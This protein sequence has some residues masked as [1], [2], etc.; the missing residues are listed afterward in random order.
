MG[1]NYADHRNLYRREL[2]GRRTDQHGQRHA[3]FL[4]T[5]TIFYKMPLSFLEI[6][7]KRRSVLAPNR[8]STLQPEVQTLRMLSF[9]GN[10]LSAIKSNNKEWS[11]GMC[12]A[13]IHLIMMGHLWGPGWSQVQVPSERWSEQ[14]P[15]LLKAVFKYRKAIGWC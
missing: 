4:S 11:T 7:C 10:R 9:H 13:L 8:S 15:Y 1:L 12:Q 6:Q 5:S 14:L 3:L 2:K